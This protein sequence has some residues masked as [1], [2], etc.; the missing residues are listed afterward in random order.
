[1]EVLGAV[2]DRGRRATWGGRAHRRLLQAQEL[3]SHHQG[4]T[5]YHHL[6][7]RPTRCGDP[8]EVLP[9]KE[10]EDTSKVLL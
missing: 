1:V 9:W 10:G 7:L 8:A 2:G 4:P 3:R 5:D 6:L